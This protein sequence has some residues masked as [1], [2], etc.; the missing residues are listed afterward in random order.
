MAN[1]RHTLSLLTLLITLGLLSL[2]VQE[3]S[4]LGKWVNRK[5]VVEAEFTPAQVEAFAVAEKEFFEELEKQEHVIS[6]DGI[7][8]KVTKPSRDTETFGINDILEVVYE[9]SLM[10]GTPIQRTWQDE[11]I[12][13]SEAIASTTPGRT[14]R[15]G[16][17]EGLSKA[18]NHLKVGGEYEV[19]I[20]SKL[21]FSEMGFRQSHRFD[22]L[23]D[24]PPYSPLVYQISVIGI[25]EKREL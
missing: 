11:N 6:V 25:F 5:E 1:Q 22:F 14:S 17:F 15:S 23:D 16:S 13:F 9:A 20:P 10:D 12:A 21:A 24:V 7:K 4:A 8:L 3:V 2:C 18:L 19:Y